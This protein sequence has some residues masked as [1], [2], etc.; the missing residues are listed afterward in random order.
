L[1]GKPF[2]ITSKEKKIMRTD[3]LERKEEI[4]QWIEEEKPKRFM[5][6]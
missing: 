2:N 4:L 5:C 3:I 6:E 1:R